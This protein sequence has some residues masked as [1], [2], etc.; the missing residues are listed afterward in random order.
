MTAV[1]VT[2]RMTRPDAYRHFY[3]NCI[4]TKEFTALAPG[5]IEYKTYC[6]NVGLVQTIEHQGN[7]T[8]E[9]VSI[10][11]QQQQPLIRPLLS[12]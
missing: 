6:P 10:T 11:R 8:E 12:R 4:V 3:T 1:G 5:D 2:A 9:L 7:V